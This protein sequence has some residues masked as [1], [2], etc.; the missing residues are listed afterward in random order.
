MRKNITTRTLVGLF[1]LPT[2]TKFHCQER[3]R[4]GAFSATQTAYILKAVDE[5][6]YPGTVVM[7]ADDSSLMAVGEPI[8]TQHAEVRKN[9]PDRTCVGIVYADGTTEGEIP[10]KGVSLPHWDFIPALEN[11]SADLSAIEAVK[12][13]IES[14]RASAAQAKA[15]AKAT[16]ASQKKAA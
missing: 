11:G 12:A 2:S 13:R 4:S 14:N 15:E 9:L 5:D 1:A 3:E 10:A 16:K 7:T 6:G 8:K